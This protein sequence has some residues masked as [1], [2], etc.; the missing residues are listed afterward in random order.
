VDIVRSAPLAIL[1]LKK[2]AAPL[3][4]LIAALRLPK[5]TVDVPVLKV[6]LSS[7]G[8]LT[9]RVNIV[10]VRVAPV[11]IVTPTQVA[12]APIVTALLSVVAIITSSFTPGTTPP[13]QVTPVAQ[14]PPVVVE[15]MVAEYEAWQRNIIRVIIIAQTLP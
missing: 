2:L 8:P 15:V 11:L 10:A 6:P 3:P 7:Q 13:T 5:V 14:A 4:A 9:V 1:I 12:A